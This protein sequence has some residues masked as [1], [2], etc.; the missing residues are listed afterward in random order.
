MFRKGRLSRKLKNQTHG[1]AEVF[2]QYS[3]MEYDLLLCGESIELA[4]QFI[5]VTVYDR[6][7]SVLCAF[8]DG[9]FYEMCYAIVEPLFISCSTSYAEGAVSDC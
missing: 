5:K 4:T 7:T 3:G 9:V 8:E 6:S 1:L 2:L